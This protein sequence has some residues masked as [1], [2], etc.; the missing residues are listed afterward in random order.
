MRLSSTRPVIYL[1]RAVYDAKMPQCIRFTSSTCLEMCLFHAVLRRKFA[2][3][4]HVLL[5]K[6]MSFTFWTCLTMCIFCVVLSRKNITET[7]L[8]NV[9]NVPVFVFNTSC[10][11]TLSCCFTSQY[12]LNTLVSLCK[13]VR[14]SCVLL[15]NA[16]VLR[17]QQVCN[18]HLSC[19]FTLQKCYKHVLNASVFNTSC[20]VSVTRCLRRKNAVMHPLYV[21]NMSWNVSVSRCFTSEI[22]PKFTCFAPQIHVF[23]VSNMSHNV[24]LLCRFK[25]QKISQK[26]P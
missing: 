6:C 3:N 25:S 7:F 4:S 9:L 16:S 11:V 5:R 1:L 10:N 17:L 19:R 23:Y 15:S 14:N 13:Y 2:R 22:R 18:A 12:L 24:Y 8:R 20:N 26:R 21:F